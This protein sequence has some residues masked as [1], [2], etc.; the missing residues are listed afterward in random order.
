MHRKVVDVAYPGDNVGL[1][2]RSVDK[3][4][5]AA[6]TIAENTMVYSPRRD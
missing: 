6:K 4:D 1:T 5:I 2:L 3:G